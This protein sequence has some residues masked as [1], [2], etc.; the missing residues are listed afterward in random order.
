[1]DEAKSQSQQSD[2][3]T[4]A[5]I[6]STTRCIVWIMGGC[7]GVSNNNRGIPPNQKA[8]F[9]HQ[10]KNKSHKSKRNSQ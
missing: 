8:K 3:D 5:G 6:G 1:M 7:E 10:D 2:G 4:D 9:T